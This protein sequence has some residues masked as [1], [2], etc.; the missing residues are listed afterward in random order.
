MEY[1]T[2][3]GNGSYL[4][5]PTNSN[6]KQEDSLKQCLGSGLRLLSM[7]SIVSVLNF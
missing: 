2:C 6:R 4:E 7:E 5:E 3:M 1:V